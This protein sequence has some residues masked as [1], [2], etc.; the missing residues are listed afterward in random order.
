MREEKFGSL[1]SAITWV[2]KLRGTGLVKAVEQVNT[3]DIWGN[4]V[5]SGS[6]NDGGR[7][8]VVAIV[9]FINRM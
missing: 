1:F 2:L 6:L 4:N 9:E 5:A 7:Q 8:R 3:Y